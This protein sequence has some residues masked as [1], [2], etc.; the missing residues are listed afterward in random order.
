MPLS[1]FV[2]EA[3]R[4]VFDD[5]CEG[6]PPSR[7]EFE[8]AAFR[9][10]IAK[11]QPQIGTTR[12]EPRSIVLEF[13][14]PDP[15]EANVVLAVRIEPPERIVFLPVPPWV[16]ENIWQGEVDGS[17]HFESDARRMAGE[18]LS[19]LD[20]DVNKKWFEPRPLLRR[21]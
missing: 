1:E 5:L 17:F 6:S 18:L 9:E 8:A 20:E 10:A 15:R 21:G 16:R 12:F 13:I 14:F 19:V 11:G 4:R 7:G 3:R 2:A